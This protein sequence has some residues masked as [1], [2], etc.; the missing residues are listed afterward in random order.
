MGH[1]VNVVLGNGIGWQNT[2]R[3]P[4]VDTGFFNMFHHTTNNSVFPVRDDIYVQLKRFF[5][6][7]VNKDRLVRRCLDRQF[8][9]FFKITFIIHDFHGPPAQNKRGSNH[10]RISNILCHVFCFFITESDAVFRLSQ[11]EFVKHLLEKI[12]VFCPVNAFRAGAN[13]GNACLL[14]GRGKVQ[15]GLAAKLNNNP[16]RF[17]FFNN[18]ENIFFCQWFEIELVRRVIVCGNR[19][20]VGVDHNGLH[21]FFF[22]GKRSVYTAVVKFNALA[23]PVGASA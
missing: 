20:R 16:V 23:D 7:F 22:K 9:V 17:F 21:A 12:P 19:F 1:L 4:G 13:D 5:K 2:G 14:E 11:V 10:Y 6:E 8:K 15:G 18:M 3:V